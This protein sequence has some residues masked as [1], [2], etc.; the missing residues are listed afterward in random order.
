MKGCVCSCIR[1]TVAP[2][3]E[4][5]HLCVMQ[6]T[7]LA[8]Q[9]STV[10][11]SPFCQPPPKRSISYSNVHLQGSGNSCCSGGASSLGQ[12]PRMAPQF[13]TAF[14]S[15]QNGLSSMSSPFGGWPPMLEQ[16]ALEGSA[17][18]GVHLYRYVACIFPSGE[19]PNLG[20]L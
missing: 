15:D 14:L 18:A 20:F 4:Y 19:Q 10:P 11:S 7:F 6:K 9:A 1:N 17:A 5:L 3:S 8:M 2:E 12:E 16:R 13:S